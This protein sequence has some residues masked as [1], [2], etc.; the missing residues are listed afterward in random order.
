MLTVKQDN[1]IS[2]VGG[3]VSVRIA[4]NE[5]IKKVDERNCFEAY[6]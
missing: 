1:Y 3:C 2:G 6:L 4:T 5:K